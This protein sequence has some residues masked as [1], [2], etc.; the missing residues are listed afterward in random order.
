MERHTVLLTGAGGVAL[1]AVIEGLRLNGYRVVAADADPNAAGLYLADRGYRIPLANDEDFAD[2]I[3]RICRTESVAALVPLVDEELLAAARVAKEL[4]IALIG[5]DPGFTALCLDKFSLM[6]RLSE[7]ELP[8]PETRLLGTGIRGMTFPLIVKPR[9]GRGSRGIKVIRSQSEWD[10]YSESTPLDPQENLVQD[11]VE[12]REFTVSVVTWRDGR[13]RAVIPKEVVDKRGI[14]RL[15]ITR[16]N[17]AIDTLCR[18][19]EERLMARGPFNVQLRLDAESG[20]PFTFE[21]NPRYSTT[22]TL[23]RAAGVDEIGAL[24]SLALGRE[25]Q[26]ST[27]EW[28]SDVVLVRRSSDAFMSADEYRERRFSIETPP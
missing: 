6:Q 16:R 25:V 24:L 27:W 1:P 3:A 23:T 19:I 11:Y 13:V 22:T 14:T 15:A 10:A 12:G 4:G 2:A 5:P 18:S 26:S 8:V 7:V 17:D 28:K 20:T 9:V 21:I